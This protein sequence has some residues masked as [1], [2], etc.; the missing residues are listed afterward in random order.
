M[1]LLDLRGLIRQEMLAAVRSA[2]QLARL[3]TAKGCHE[4]FDLASRRGFAGFEVAL[5]A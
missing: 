2:A 4:V 3:E 5:N 1:A